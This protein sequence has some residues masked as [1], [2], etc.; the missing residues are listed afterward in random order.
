MLLRSDEELENKLPPKP[1]EGVENKLDWPKAGVVC[2]NAEEVCPKGELVCPSE[3]VVD[4]NNGE[5]WVLPKPPKPVPNADVV[6]CDVEAPKIDGD[7][8]GDELDC[9][10]TEGDVLPPNA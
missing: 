6:P 9:P 5:D 7:P 8:K 1:V 2:P 3:G 4:W 10:N